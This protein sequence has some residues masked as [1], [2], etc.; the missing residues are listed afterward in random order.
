M[1]CPT[2]ETLI[3][4][5]DNRLAPEA[6]SIVETHV[7]TGC[8]SCRSTIDWFTGFS[9]A[10]SQDLVEPP[11][12][13][14]R[15]AVALFAQRQKEGIVA[16]VTRLVAS[17]VFDSLAVSASPDFVPARSAAVSGRQLLF[18]A[19]PFDIDLLVSAGDAPRTVAVTGQ[20]L[21]ADSAEFASVAGLGVEFVRNG[22]PVASAVTSDFGE[23][24]IDSLPPGSYDV[25]V[26]DSGREI[27]LTGAPIEIR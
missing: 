6:A 15:K 3:D 11:V 2:F 26:S 22:E 18:T 10:A 16:K 12:W 14:T 23:F 4:F 17:L 8:A 24:A 21:S 7:D 25:F 13:L 1:P 5:T 19:S 20:V 27:V 9:A